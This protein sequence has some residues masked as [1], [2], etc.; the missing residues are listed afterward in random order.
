MTILF[1]LLSVI[2]AALLIFTI[3]APKKW[4]AFVLKENRFWRNRNFISESTLEK[5]VIFETGVWLKLLLFIGLI[6]FILIAY[7]IV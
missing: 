1:L 6:G 3:L 4:H 5:M 2:W 7:F